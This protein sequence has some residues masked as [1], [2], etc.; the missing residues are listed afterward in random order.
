[1]SYTRLTDKEHARVKLE[2]RERIALEL[3]GQ[4]TCV[5]PMAETFN[6]TWCGRARTAHTMKVFFTRALTSHPPFPI[7]H[8]GGTPP[9][10][11]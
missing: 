6:G 3:V 10:N 4:L 1:M 5:S 7:P 8:K 2:W 11:C 9:E